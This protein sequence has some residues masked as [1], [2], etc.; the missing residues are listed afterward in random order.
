MLFVVIRGAGGEPCSPRD[1]AVGNE[2]LNRLLNGERLDPLLQPVAGSSRMQD[3]QTAADI[4]ES[5]AMAAAA[6]ADGARSKVRFAPPR[7]M[8]LDE[9]AGGAALPSSSSSSRSSTGNMMSLVERD[10][11][12]D[13]P[14][15]QGE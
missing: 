10:R 15:L 6:T 11:S 1:L 3:A 14:S 7:P 8:L 9:A 4:R 13:L 12:P 2:R 5:N